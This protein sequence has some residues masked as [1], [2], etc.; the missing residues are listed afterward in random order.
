MKVYDYF[1]TLVLPAYL[2][3]KALIASLGTQSWSEHGNEEECLYPCLDSIQCV[4]FRFPR[5]W[6]WSLGVQI[7]WDVMLCCV[8]PD[9]RKPSDASHKSNPSSV[10]RDIIDSYSALPWVMWEAVTFVEDVPWWGLLWHSLAN[11]AQDYP[12]QGGRYRAEGCMALG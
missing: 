6:V 2:Q 7:F 1:H 8:D 4:G 9:V 5:S 11:G 3:M 12:S 10:P